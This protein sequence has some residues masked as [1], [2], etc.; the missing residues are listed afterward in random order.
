MALVVPARQNLQSA[1]RHVRL[2]YPWQGDN[3]FLDERKVGAQE[4]MPQFVADRIAM[5]RQAT[6]ALPVVAECART[7]AEPRLRKAGTAV[8]ARAGRRTTLRADL[9]V[10]AEVQRF[11]AAVLRQ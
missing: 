8:A 6:G 1:A 5:L 9:H 7:D 2:V 10:S 11:A 4:P 3:A